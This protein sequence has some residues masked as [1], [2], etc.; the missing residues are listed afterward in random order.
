MDPATLQAIMEYILD[1]RDREG[2]SREDNGRIYE[3]TATVGGYGGG[4]PNVWSNATG[5]AEIGGNEAGTWGGPPQDFDMGGDGL[6]SATGGNPAGY[7]TSPSTYGGPP[8]QPRA[9]MAELL[10]M[11]GLYDP[12]PAKPMAGR[13]DGPRSAPTPE[14]K[15]RTVNYPR[16]PQA[17]GNRAETP[18]RTGMLPNGRAFPG[19]GPRGPAANIQQTVQ[20]LAQR[21]SSFGRPP[22]PTGSFGPANVPYSAPRV[23]RPAPAPRPVSNPPAA[24]AP[25]QQFSAPTQRA[26]PQARPA[27]TPPAAPALR[28]ALSALTRRR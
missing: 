1:L 3:D 10:A 4:L 11:S 28:A 21:A 13:K 15:D 5:R 25:R 8:P 26:A 2:R 18:P 14:P 6:I 19:V 16:D 7:D 27:Y 23:Q 22:Q 20:H 17:R 9:S 24:P 12:G